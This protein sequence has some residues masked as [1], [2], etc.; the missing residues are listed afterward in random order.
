MTT[1]NADKYLLLGIDQFCFLKKGS[2][3]FKNDDQ[4]TKNETVVFKN[5]RFIKL[6]NEEVVF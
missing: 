3:R 2:F 1:L 5:Y 4:K 6:K